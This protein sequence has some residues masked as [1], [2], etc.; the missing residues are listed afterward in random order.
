MSITEQ[1]VYDNENLRERFLHFIDPVEPCKEP[2][3]NVCHLPNFGDRVPSIE[4][5][6]DGENPF[7]SWVDKLL[8]DIFDKF[9]L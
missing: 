7:V 6:R 1:S 5:T 2:S 3:I 4:C 8:V 9:I